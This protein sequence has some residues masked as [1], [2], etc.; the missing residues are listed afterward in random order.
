MAE[1]SQANIDCKL[2]FL[3]GVD[4]CGLKFQ[5][6]GDVPIKYSS[7]WENQNDHPFIWCKNAGRRLCHSVRVH[8]FDG[9]TESDSKSAL[10]ESDAR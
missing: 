9:Q 8:A 4:Q 10:T 5:V 2:A 1:A 6:K 3:N 7:C